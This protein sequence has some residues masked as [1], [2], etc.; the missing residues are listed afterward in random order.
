MREE[1]ETHGVRLGV[2]GLEAVVE[3]AEKFVE[4]VALGLLVP[5]AGGAMGVEVA[6]GSGGS[7]QRSQWPDRAD[8]G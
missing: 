2:A 5:V 1:G 4:Q 7:T 6:A 8:S 3:L